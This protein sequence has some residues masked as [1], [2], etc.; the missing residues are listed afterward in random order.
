MSHRAHRSELFYTVGVVCKLLLSLQITVRWLKGVLYTKG[1][2]TP[3]KMFCKPYFWNLVLY[4]YALS[5]QA[6]K[7]P[8]VAEIM[9]SRHH[10]A[11]TWRHVEKAESS[12]SKSSTLQYS[13]GSVAVTRGNEQGHLFSVIL[14][15]Q[16]FAN[17]S[18]SGIFSPFTSRHT[19]QLWKLL[20]QLWNQ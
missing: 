11:D 9:R 6:G 12:P 10:E 20:L 4:L 5:P 15:F 14:T 8:E 17:K 19:L 16:S 2:A 13:Q 1:N 3:R 7:H 18:F